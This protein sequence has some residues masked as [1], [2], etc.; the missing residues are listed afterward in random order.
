MYL[1]IRGLNPNFEIKIL[2]TI[3]GVGVDFGIANSRE[4]EL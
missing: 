4:L 2:E 3:R 1:N